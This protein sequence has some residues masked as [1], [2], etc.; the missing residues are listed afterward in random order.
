[1]S[2]RI[3]FSDFLR[4]ILVLEMLLAFGCRTSKTSVYDQVYN[5]TITYP[6]YYEAKK[7]GNDGR[8]EK[9]VIRTSSG[10]TEY[11]LEIPENVQDY[12]IEVPVADI[13]AGRKEPSARNVQMSDREL[14]SSMPRLSRAAEEEKALM[15]KAFG[16]AESGGPKQSPSYLLSLQKINEL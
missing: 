10:N 7:I 12:D 11:S 5:A 1:M 15:D 2:S 13:G 3:I 9:L 6:F 14:V 4:M 16:V 8:Q